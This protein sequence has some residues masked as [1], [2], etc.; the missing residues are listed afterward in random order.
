M[1]DLVVVEEIGKVGKVGRI[2]R[3]GVEIETHVDGGSAKQGL[4][5]KSVGTA[6][7]RLDNNEL[8]RRIHPF[9]G[10]KECFPER[11]PEGC[12]VRLVAMPTAK[13]VETNG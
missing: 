6:F 3:G 1:V 8:G 13:R 10:R 9:L 12:Q 7:G 5:M 4:K 2:E 11:G